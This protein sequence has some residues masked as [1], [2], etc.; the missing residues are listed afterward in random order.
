MVLLSFSKQ[1][2]QQQQVYFKLNIAYKACP[3]ISEGYSRRVQ[4]KK[5]NCINIYIYTRLLLGLFDF[6]N[7]PVISETLI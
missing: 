3:A 6:E 2:Q 4:E 7:C 1:Q 5:E